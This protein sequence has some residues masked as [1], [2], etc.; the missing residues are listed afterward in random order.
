[1]ALQYSFNIYVYVQYGT[2]SSLSDQIKVLKDQKI[3][4]GVI[5]N[6]GAHISARRYKVS[7]K[8]QTSWIS[9]FFNSVKRLFYNEPIILE[10]CPKGPYKN[11]KY[12]KY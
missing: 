3:L 6:V 10:K 1:M 2:V 8:T 7:N 4:K 12:L 5:S 9:R 11:G